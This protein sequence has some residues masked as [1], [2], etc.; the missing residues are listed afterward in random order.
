MTSIPAGHDLYP[1]L[2]SSEQ[3]IFFIEYASEPPVHE[4]EMEPGLRPV[5]FSGA[6]VGAGA[7]QYFVCFSRPSRVIWPGA[8]AG[9]VRTFFLE[10]EPE[11]EPEPYHFAHRTGT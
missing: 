5:I 2:G 10:P 9:V 7:V 8:E 6:R 3:A 4:S 11:S 1:E